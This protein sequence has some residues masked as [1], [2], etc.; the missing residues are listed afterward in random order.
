MNIRDHV[1]SFMAA[2]GASACYALCIY[3]IAKTWWEEQYPGR[4]FDYDEL[5]ALFVGVEKGF[6]EF[7]EDN[8][9]APGNFYVTYPKGFIEYLTG[10]EWQV[11]EDEAEYECLRDEYEVQFW[12]WNA[13]KAARREGHFIR[14]G[15]NTLVYSRSVASGACF[16]KRIYKFIG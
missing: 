11:R 9:N 6:I 16:K 14:P 13:E 4:K 2:A 5:E 8:Y 10:R 3:D 7:H 1:Q 15:K 12:A